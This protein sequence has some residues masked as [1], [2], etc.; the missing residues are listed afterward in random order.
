MLSYGFKYHVD[1]IKYLA[2]QINEYNKSECTDII[3]MDVEK[4][5]EYAIRQDD[6]MMFDWILSFFDINLDKF[7]CTI[8]R[9]VFFADAIKIYRYCTINPIIRE[10]FN[11]YICFCYN[12][13]HILGC[14][15]SNT[16]ISEQ[17]K[18]D[19]IN[20][21]LIEIDSYKIFKHIF[22]RID[23]VNSNKILD[24]THLAEEK[25]AVKIHSILYSLIVDKKSY[26]P[27]MTNALASG[28]V[29]MI[30]RLISLGCILPPI[31]ANDLALLAVTWNQHMVNF[32]CR[33]T[34]IQFRF[35]SIYVLTIPDKFA[36]EIIIRNTQLYLSGNINHLVYI[37]E[38]ALRE[39]GPFRY[40]K[41]AI[42][43]IAIKVSRRLSQEK[44]QS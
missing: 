30:E 7:Y 27:S 36:I 11:T 18:I 43:K 10:Y 12:N 6:V 29:D 44:I 3:L 14:L 26:I 41:K 23:N 35:D 13:R 24:L 1:T 38:E 37:Y 28:S 20:N 5:F 25:G 15:A 2:E 9:S 16:I 39:L 31:N 34:G 40:N 22:D 33:K 19:S 21:A 42:L 8:R 32:L 4:F 17:E